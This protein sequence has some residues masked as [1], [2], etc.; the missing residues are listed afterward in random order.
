VNSPTAPAPASPVP[1]RW[2]LS[3][4]GRPLIGGVTAA[5]IPIPARRLIG[6]AE[7]SLDK[8]FFGAKILGYSL[9]VRLQPVV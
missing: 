4:L 7:R 3:A 5:R 2:T 9:V 1:L 6:Y 8:S